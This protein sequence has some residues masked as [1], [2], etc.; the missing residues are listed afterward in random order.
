MNRFGL[1]AA[2]VAASSLTAWAADEYH[3]GRARQPLIP[4]DQWGVLHNSK[5]LYDTDFAH[6][7]PWR[8][9]YYNKSR[10]ELANDPAYMGALQEALRRNGYYC[11]PIDGV[12]SDEVSHAIALLQ[13]NY[14]YRVNG[15]LTISVRR[16]LFLP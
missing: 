16:A 9:F 11:G 13:K 1:V 8:L 6:Q 10:R 15:A 5:E 7:E 4:R 12:F 14:G 3:V 2:L